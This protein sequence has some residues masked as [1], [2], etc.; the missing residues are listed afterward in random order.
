MLPIFA[1]A[2]KFSFEVNPPTTLNVNIGDT[3]SG[4]ASSKNMHPNYI[5]YLRLS[6]EVSETEES[7]ITFTPS[8]YSLNP[9]ETNTLSYSINIPSN[10]CTG[11]YT[12]RM[13]ATLYNYADVNDPTNYFIS[14]QGSTGTAMSASVGYKIRLFVNGIEC[15]ETITRSVYYDYDGNGIFE[16]E[17]GDEVIT[18]GT[19][20]IFNSSDQLISTT[21]LSTTNGIYQIPTGT[22]ENTDDFY[23][24][25]DLNK[26]IASRLDTTWEGNFYV[27]RNGNISTPGNAYYFRNISSYSQL[28]NNIDIRSRNT[29]RMGVFSSGTKTIGPDD[30]D[31]IIA[32]GRWNQLVNNTNF[33]YADLDHDGRID[34]DDKDHII[35]PLYW[36]FPN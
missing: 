11:Q 30:K 35:S 27:N 5:T 6:D 13:K 4:T 2:P 15:G 29:D 36:N 25:V 12:I 21:D 26:F 17:Q 28:N 22:L 16:P 34:P 31:Q 24:T 14:S 8:S 20:K 33:K 19:F 3:I 32:I 10:T 7:W 23:A 1:E 18:K 9:L